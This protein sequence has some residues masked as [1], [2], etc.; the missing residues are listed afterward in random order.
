MQRSDE[1]QVRVCLD[2]GYPHG[3]AVQ[4]SGNTALHHAA[5]AAN[6]A[7]INWLVAAGADPNARNTMGRTALHTAALAGSISNCASLA[8]NGADVQAK[9][10]YGH[11]PKDAALAHQ[12][13]SCVAVLDSLLASQLIESMIDGHF[14]K[15]AKAPRR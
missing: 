1:A 10:K 13:F 15:V 4:F 6:P 2:Q 14:L 11:T 5:Q 7:F 9:D 12:E 8:R 3:Q